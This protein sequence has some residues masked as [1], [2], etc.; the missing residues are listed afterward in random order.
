L[1]LST[2]NRNNREALLWG[3]WTLRVLMKL[4]FVMMSMHTAPSTLAKKY[5]R[6]GRVPWVA[7]LAMLKHLFVDVIRIV[8]EL[9]AGSSLG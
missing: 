8:L 5:H 1:P 9:G 7:D 2:H 4:V 6:S 3:S